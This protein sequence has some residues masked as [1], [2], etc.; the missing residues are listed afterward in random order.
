MSNAV[1]EHIIDCSKY[2]LWNL[3]ADYYPISCVE[4]LQE[5]KISVESNTDGR[6]EI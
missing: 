1:S 6:V 2:P 5:K 3:T 4:K